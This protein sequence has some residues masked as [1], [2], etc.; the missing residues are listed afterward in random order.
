MQNFATIWLKRQSER[1]FVMQR[2]ENQEHEIKAN[3][4][5]L[6]LLQKQVKK[7]V[8]ADSKAESECLLNEMHGAAAI[9]DT[10]RV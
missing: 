7:A 3:T 10:Q 1:S 2:G 8:A 4:E 5:K 9:F 6:K